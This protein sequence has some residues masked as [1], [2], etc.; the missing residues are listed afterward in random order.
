[1]LI[2]I[3][4]LMLK[5]TKLVKIT[6]KT[7]TF[8]FITDNYAVQSQYLTTNIGN[9]IS[10]F[11]PDF[12]DPVFSR[13]KQCADLRKVKL[14]AILTILLPNSNISVLFSC[15]GMWRA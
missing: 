8:F 12:P 10:G 9:F 3:E 7:S 6:K 5:M 11:F 2:A 4:I 14:S 15:G 13:K 1:M